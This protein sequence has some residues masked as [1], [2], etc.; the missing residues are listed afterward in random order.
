MSD[1]DSECGGSNPSSRANREI[2]YIRRSSNGL[3]R[4]DVQ[5]NVWFKSH[6][7]SQERAIRTEIV[8]K[9]VSKVGGRIRSVHPLKSGP[10]RMVQTLSQETHHCGLRLTA[11]KTALIDMGAY[12]VM[13][14][15]SHKGAASQ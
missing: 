8:C 6:L 13:T 7:A 11:S 3:G 14:C 15:S 10:R 2:E 4:G 12:E 5:P 9:S 1:S